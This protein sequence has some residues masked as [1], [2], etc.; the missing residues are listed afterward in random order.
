M[1]RTGTGQARF[2]KF[3]YSSL[4]ERLGFKPYCGGPVEFA[5]SV[6]S[7]SARSVGSLAVTIYD[8]H[9]TKLVNADT[10]SLGQV[11]GLKQGRTLVRLRIKELHLNPGVYVLGLWLASPAGEVFDYLT[12]AAKIEVVALES[13]TFGLGGRPGADG[14]VVC[15]FE[16][17][18]DEQS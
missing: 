7:D 6:Y 15:H 17:E 2:T 3:W 12:S 11:V 9:G 5:L 13:G 8:Q 10:V 14:A 4:N 1:A 16:L 18:V